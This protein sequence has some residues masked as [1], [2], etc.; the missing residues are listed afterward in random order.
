MNKSCDTERQYIIAGKSHHLI[1]GALQRDQKSCL[2]AMK[3]T[4]GPRINAIF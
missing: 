2:E 4:T 1:P 3:P